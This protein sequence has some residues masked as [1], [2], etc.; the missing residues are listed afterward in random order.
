MDKTPSKIRG[1]FNEIAPK[2]DFMN[3]LMSILL[4]RF[5]KR[6]ALKSLEIKNDMCILDCCTGTGDVV[7]ILKKEYQN[8]DVIGIDFSQ[9]MLDIAQKKISD[10]KFIQADCTK[11]PFPNNH[12]DIVTIFFGLRNIECYENAINEMMRV[13]RQGGQL[14]HLDFG[15]NLFLNKIFDILVKFLAKIFI[16]DFY[17]YKYLIDSKNQFFTPKELTEK[18]EIF[19]FRKKIAKN[20]LF[21]IISMQIFEK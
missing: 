4:H 8:I 6:Q 17:A 3:D 16:H 14:C 1:M 21:G 12:F 9:K 10:A 7:K 5:V 15:K 19:G 11:I 18:F 2:Y 13:L 20:Y